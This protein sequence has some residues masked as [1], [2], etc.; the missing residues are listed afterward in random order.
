MKARRS[1]PRHHLDPAPVDLELLRGIIATWAASHPAIRAVWLIG[2]RAKGT[3]R[4]DSDVD[5]AVAYRPSES[6]GDDFWQYE[7]WREELQALIPYPVHLL[8]CRRERQH[9]WS[10][11]RERRVPLYWR[12]PGLV[13]GAGPTATGAA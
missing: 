7:D 10:G 4:P 9:V 3:A 2:S 8:T 12:A 11:A 5:L 1:D 6:F 13:L